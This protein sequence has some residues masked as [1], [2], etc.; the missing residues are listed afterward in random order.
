MA[1]T[2]GAR[3]VRLARGQVLHY[4]DGAGR[5]VT[6]CAGIV[7]VTQQGANTVLRAGERLELDC[8]VSAAVRAIEG[9]RS[10]WHGD[11]GIA[12]ICVSSRRTAERA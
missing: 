4:D 9:F 8:R 2:L 3:S 11:S 5:T 12:V 6:C 10:V 1:T 7:H